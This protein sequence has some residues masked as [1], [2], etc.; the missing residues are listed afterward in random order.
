L[1][2]EDIDDVLS[3]IYTDLQLSVAACTTN[4][5]IN[6][7]DDGLYSPRERILAGQLSN[8]LM[9]SVRSDEDR[10]VVAKQQS[11]LAE[12]Y[13]IVNQFNSLIALETASQ[14]RDLDRYDNQDNKYD[15]ALEDFAQGA[16]EERKLEPNSAVPASEESWIGGGGETQDSLNLIE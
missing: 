10:L 13:T 6:K 1:D 12:K 4:K 2:E 16:S 11:L 15:T 3:S 7:D 9:K 14:Q 8:V 5:T